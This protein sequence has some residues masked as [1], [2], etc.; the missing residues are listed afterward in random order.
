MLA[1]LRPIKTPTELVGI[2]KVNVQGPD[3]INCDIHAYEEEESFLSCGDVGACAVGDEESVV[4]GSG[5]TEEP[6]L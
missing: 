1:P 6:I 3:G 2:Y 4:L 5:A